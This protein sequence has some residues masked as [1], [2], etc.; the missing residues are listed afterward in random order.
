MYIDDVCVSSVYLHHIWHNYIY[1]K[2]THINI[3][4]YF[5]HFIHPN[6]KSF[7]Q[8]YQ[9]FF[10]FPWTSETLRSSILTE[11]SPWAGVTRA[12]KN[13]AMPNEL[14]DSNFVNLLFA[15]EKT[16]QPPVLSFLASNFAAWQAQRR[17]L[18]KNAQRAGAAEFYGLGKNHRRACPGMLGVSLHHILC[19]R[20]VLLHRD[21]VVAFCNQGARKP[22]GNTQVGCEINLS[23]RCVAPSA[24]C[25]APSATCIGISAVGV[26]AGGAAP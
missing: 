2:N 16:T 6:C 18:W 7:H 19:L 17:N 13:W 22:I 23:P 20:R 12:G 15:A 3:P 5:N 9:V 26:V 25:V 1:I 4:L 8:L 24:T 10:D 11:N 21:R 14:L